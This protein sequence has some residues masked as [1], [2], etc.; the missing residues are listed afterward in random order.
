MNGEPTPKARPAAT[1]TS[2]FG[3]CLFLLGSGACSEPAREGLVDVRDALNQAGEALDAAIRQSARDVEPHAREAGE[4]VV[5]TLSQAKAKLQQTGEAVDQVAES[6]QEGNL[7]PNAIACAEERYT[8]TRDVAERV[9]KTPMALALEAGVEETD[10]GAR[11]TEVP[12]GGILARLGLREGDVIVGVSGLDLQGP[13]DKPLS[14]RLVSKEVTL[15]IERDGRRIDK[16]IMLA[17]DA[18]VAGS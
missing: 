9:A 3:L 11:V 5:E 8:V 13:M 15:A 16:T 14:E 4:E 12:P 6:Q 1:R 2:A 7:D 10:R 17:E 18:P